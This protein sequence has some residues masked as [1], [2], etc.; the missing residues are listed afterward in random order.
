MPFQ[1]PV[2]SQKDFT[3]IGFYQEDC[4]LWDCEWALRAAIYGLCALLHASPYLQRAEGQGYSSQ[5]DRQEEHIAA[6]LTAKE[7][8]LNHPG[9]TDSFKSHLVDSLA[10][11]WF[12]TAYF[13]TL[14]R[15]P[16]DAITAL[17]QSKYYRLQLKQLKLLARIVLNAIVDRILGP[18]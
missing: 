7:R 18:T 12:D 16:L 17:W 13:Y 2:L 5:S 15:R 8:L 6:M 11:S 3:R 4:L 10:Q 14:K 1:R 9:L